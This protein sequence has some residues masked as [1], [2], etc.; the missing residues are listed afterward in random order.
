VVDE[1]AVMDPGWPLEGTQTRLTGSHTSPPA[2][3]ALPLQP[4]LASTKKTH[5]DSPK[6]KT[7]STGN[8]SG[9]MG[10]PSRAGGRLGADHSR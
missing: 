2:Q 8:L 4:R 5:P 6:P 7:A 3:S 10:A 9:L 1:L